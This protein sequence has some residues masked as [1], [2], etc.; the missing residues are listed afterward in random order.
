MTIIG[1]EN[2]IIGKFYM[3]T[4]F[5]DHIY[6][7]GFWNNRFCQ[8]QSKELCGIACKS[9]WLLLCWHMFVFWVGCIDRFLRWMSFLARHCCRG[10]VPI[11][12]P[13]SAFGYWSKSGQNYES[14]YSFII[15]SSSLSFLFVK[16][17]TVHLLKGIY[18]YLLFP[19]ILCLTTRLISK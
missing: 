1:I 12:A 8:R 9:G 7:Y 4:V 3:V 2:G 6:L 16:S 18:I 14:A 19:R 13:S 17:A 15:F 5:Y 10:F 11:S